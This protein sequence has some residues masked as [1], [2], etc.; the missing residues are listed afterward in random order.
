[1]RIRFETTIDDALALSRHEFAHSRRYWWL[2]KFPIVVGCLVLALITISVAPFVWPGGGVPG[3]ALVVIAT[4]GA[5][6][7]LAFALLRSI[8]WIH[9]WHVRKKLQGHDGMLKIGWHEIQLDDGIFYVT[10]EWT[11]YHIDVRAIAGIAV[12]GRWAFVMIESCQSFVV[13]LYQFANLEG[14]EFIAELQE[15]WEHSNHAT[16]NEPPPLKLS[17]PDERIKEV[18]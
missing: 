10:T 18:R 4:C 13:P 3:Q 14:H 17:A 15:A 2:V 1:M 11:M 8:V 6:F 9:S 7:L 12:S 16:S 5:T